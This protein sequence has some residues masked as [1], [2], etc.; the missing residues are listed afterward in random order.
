MSQGR[1]TLQ[2]YI[3]GW[4]LLDICPFCFKVEVYLKLARIPYT[5]VLGDPRKAP[6]RKLPVLL[7][8]DDTVP[9]SVAIIDHLERT[10]AAPLDAFLSVQQRALATAVR[11]MVEGAPRLCGDRDAP[12]RD[13]R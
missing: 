11:S 2:R 12:A 1:V 9:D 6:K 4:E 7:D 10:R 13:S 8:G 5:T 3:P